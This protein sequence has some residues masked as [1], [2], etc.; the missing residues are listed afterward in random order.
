LAVLSL[1]TLLL[2]STSVL[3]YLK[4]ETTAAQRNAERREEELNRLKETEKVRD[5][6]RTFLQKA[7]GHLAGKA[8]QGALAAAQTALS[9]IDQN[10]KLP[11]EEELRFEA[12]DLKEQAEEQMKRREQEEQARAAFDDSFKKHYDDALFFTSPSNGLPPDVSVAR[13]GAK[14]REA[15]AVFTDGAGTDGPAKSVKLNPLFS[16]L[17]KEKQSLVRE[18][19]YE[20]LLVLAEAE[21]R[22][23]PA[24]PPIERNERLDRAVRLLD[25]AQSLRFQ[26][27]AWHER[28]A[29]YLERLG[30]KQQ[31]E[32]ERKEADRLR[33]QLEQ[34]GAGAQPERVVDLFLLGSTA[35]LRGQLER[36][37]LLLER[38]VRLRPDHLWARHLLVLG[39]L[40]RG[41]PGRAETHLC[42]CLEQRRDFVWFYL[43][44]AQAHGMLADL[45]RRAQPPQPGRVQYHFE[46]AQEDYEQAGSRVAG[47]DTARY[48]LHNNRGMLWFQQGEFKRAIN[49]L[50]QALAYGR[51]PDRSRTRDLL[52]EVYR[53][54]KVIIDNR[55]TH[56]WLVDATAE[57]NKAITLRPDQPDLYRRRALIQLERGKV[58]EA[59]DDLNTAIRLRQASK[60]PAQA[61]APSPAGRAENLAA[62][63]DD[64]TV[65]GRTLQDAGESAR[66]AGAFATAVGEFSRAVDAFDKAL[67]VADQLQQLLRQEQLP[68]VERLDLP[69]ARLGRAFCLLRCAEHP[70]DPKKKQELL[71]EVIAAYDFALR[72]ARVRMLPEAYHG[73]AEARLSR[74]RPEDLAGAVQD[75]TVA[76]L[77][78]E[79]PRP[80]WLAQRGW[81]YLD[82]LGAAQLA[83]ADFEKVL[84]LRSSDGD[85]H[86]GRALALA[87]LS[88]DRV[89]ATK[90]AEQALV[91]ARKMAGQSGKSKEAARLFANVAR[92]YVRLGD[93]DGAAD[94]LAEAFGSLP[95]AKAKRQFWRDVVDH[96]VADF[97]PILRHPKVRRMNDER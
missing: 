3:Y 42:T 19:I 37:V 20:L 13:A 17:E 28:R 88:R 47:D 9:L 72:S 27:V 35:Y 64:L 94:S 50:K 60:P 80:A 18:R 16:H 69:E 58:K 36:A 57:A 73:R 78:N 31:A 84:E 2:G 46:R 55:P 30:A 67:A 89:A 61:G 10:P 92:A 81:L 63:L 49:E 66:R 54:Y 65:L 45:A 91:L 83:L 62:L 52:A 34:G 96:N 11:E 87:R 53:G 71:S 75:Y 25:R 7:K 68:G 59:L 48:V 44:R 74:G 39:Y 26:T 6:V 38:A 33:A 76:L 40:Q 12:Q 24:G 1:V 70:P 43:D 56:P 32:Q 15:L 5:E 95:D 86:A 14:A 97:E 41:E 4:S 77:L 29:D 79:S 90:D 23:A 82:R 85:G 8:W 21:A 22:S 51:D 93:L